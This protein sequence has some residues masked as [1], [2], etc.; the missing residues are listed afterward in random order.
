MSN[1]SFIIVIA[2]L[3][4]VAIIGSRAY[5]PTRFDAASIATVTDFPRQIGDWT[6][7]DIPINELTY[8]ILETKNVVMRKY[9]NKNGDAVYLYIVYSEQN[10]RVVHP[11][12]ICMTGAGMNILEKNPIQ[13]TD[14]IRAV[15]MLMEKAP[16]RELVVYWFKVGDFYTDKFLK[17]QLRVA[18][19]HTLGRRMPAGLI[20]LS[21]TIKDNDEKT[22]L[23]LLRTFASLIQTLL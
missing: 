12:E 21:T 6:G 5:L 15:R 23:E 14:S 1:R 17:Q 8:N 9:K 22:A 10:R 2:I 19:E 18:W 4:V 11:P 20:R 7:E 13:L 16:L 3:L